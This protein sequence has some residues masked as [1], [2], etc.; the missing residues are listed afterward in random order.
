VKTPQKLW[1]VLWKTPR[2]KKWRPRNCFV[3]LSEARR[4][5]YVGMQNSP[6]MHHAIRAVMVKP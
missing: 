6:H 2:Q 4:S 1:L 5:F 3:K